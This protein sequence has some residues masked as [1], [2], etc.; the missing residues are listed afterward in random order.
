MHCIGATKCFKN[1][2]SP[3]FILSMTFMLLSPPVESNQLLWRDSIRLDVFIMDMS[4]PIC[5]LDN[6]KL[7][8]HLRPKLKTIG[9]I[10]SCAT[11]PV[12]CPCFPSDNWLRYWLKKKNPASSYLHKLDSTVYIMIAT[13]GIPPADTVKWCC[14]LLS[15]FAPNPPYT[16]NPHPKPLPKKV[17]LPRLAYTRLYFWFSDSFSFHCLCRWDNSKWKSNL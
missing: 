10:I 11:I 15:F 14:H 6:L 9:K 13:R 3:I 12:F 4:V 8:W 16:L 17:Q 7:I 2:L 5:P 1:I